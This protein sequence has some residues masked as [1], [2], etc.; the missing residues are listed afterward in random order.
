MNIRPP[1]PNYR[2]GGDSGQ[3]ACESP[4]V[5]LQNLKI[6][7]LLYYSPSGSWASFLL[8]PHY[9]VLTCIYN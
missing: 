9:D 3:M 6:T 8:L 5:A 2:S 1:P 7:F 4:F